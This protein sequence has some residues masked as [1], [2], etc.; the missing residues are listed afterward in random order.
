MTALPLARP[1]PPLRAVALLGSLTVAVAA[2]AAAPTG[3]PSEALLVGTSFG[4]ALLGLAIAGGWRAGPVRRQA[5]AAGLA[6]GAVLVAMAGLLA[7]PVGL[8][9]LRSA[10]PFLPWVAVTALVVMAEEA[11]FRGALFD[12]LERSGGAV[13]AVAVTSLAFALMHVPLY[14]WQV[15]PLDLGVGLWFA[16]LRL[17]GGGVAAPAIAHL[18]ADV[19]TWWL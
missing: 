11:V 18:L 9:L 10:A 14:G 15:L 6:G 1:W 5:V 2:R 17:A 3:S 8:P 19:A 13:M 7:P 12:A 16:G 4:L